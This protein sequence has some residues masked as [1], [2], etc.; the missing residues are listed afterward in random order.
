MWSIKNSNNALVLKD[1]QQIPTLWL[2]FQRNPTIHLI[3]WIFCWKLLGK[4]SNKFQQCTFFKKIP[5]NSNIIHFFFKNSNKFQHYA[6]FF[7]KFPTKSNNLLDFFEFC[8]KLLGKK[9]NVGKFEFKSFWIY[10]VIQ[11]Y[12]KKGN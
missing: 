3:F 11:K 12:L 8:W 6:L 7:Q 10:F 4:K 9:S 2:N 1:F 5:T